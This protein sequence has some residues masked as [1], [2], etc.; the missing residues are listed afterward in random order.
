MNAMDEPFVASLS[1]RP[2]AELD[3]YLARPLDYHTGA[4]EAVLA[5]LQR[6][7]RGP[8][9]PELQH[10]R[11]VLAERDAAAQRPA[12]HGMVARLGDSLP[13]RLRRIH[14]LVALLLGLGLGSAGALWVAAPPDAPHPLGY[15]PT[16]TKK[17]LRDLELYGGKVNVLATEATAWWHARW[18]GRNLAVTVAVLTLALAGGFQAVATRRAREL[19]AALENPGV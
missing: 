1:R 11:S 16:D 15:E 9:A 7:G 2:E 19:E 12:A 18:Q 10:L 4:V 5:E 17:Y 3:A 13:T 6:R 8:A 14:Q